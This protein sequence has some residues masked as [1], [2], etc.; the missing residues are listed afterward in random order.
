MFTVA[1]IATK[2]GEVGH[3]AA[4]ILM[5]AA[6]GCRIFAP[7]WLQY[8]IL[9]D[10]VENRAE[11]SAYSLNVIVDTSS[12]SIDTTVFVLFALD[13]VIVFLLM[14]LVFRNLYCIIKNS[15]RTTPFQPENVRRLTRIG[16]F[17]IIVP[18]VS[19]IMGPMI[20]ALGPVVLRAEATGDGYIMGILVFC[21]T[22]VFARGVELEKEVDGLL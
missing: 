19:G 3:W 11:L 13:A 8:F 7:Q 12:G 18:V 21:L 6:A 10:V 1:K 17:A 16:V 20:R 15:E 2:I 9:V 4:T 14:A 5:A 22:Q